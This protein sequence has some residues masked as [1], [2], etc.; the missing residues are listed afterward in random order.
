LLPSEHPEAGDPTKDLEKRLAALS[1]EALAR[2]VAIGLGER[3]DD[4]EAALRAPL[5]APVLIRWAKERRRIP[6]LYAALS[7]EST[8]D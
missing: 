6:D 2:L 4:V 1:P 8:A 7:G 3:P 5:S